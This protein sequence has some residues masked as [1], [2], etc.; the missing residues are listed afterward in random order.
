MEP[1]ADQ[2]DPDAA[3]RR[4]D[5]AEDERDGRSEAE[6]DSDCDCDGESTGKRHGAGARSGADEVSDRSALDRDVAVHYAELRDIAQRAVNWVHAGRP[7]NPTEL[8][9]EGYI[10]LRH[11]DAAL[12]PRPTEFLALAAS[13]LRNC[14]ID[15]VRELRAL[16]RGGD[17][18]R[19]TL[20]GLELGAHREIDLLE[21][22]D[23]LERLAVLDRR[24]AQIVELK[25][26]G[27]LSLAA[28]GEVLGVGERMVKS[29]WTLAT[30]WLHRELRG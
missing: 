30:A 29:E 21:L 16:K 1:P 9:H 24:Q 23:A 3:Q 5:R 27:G 11:R 18:Q 13:V 25:Y 10:R 26:F 19:V 2:P 6:G 7:L 22:D 14:L 4:G 28:I 12:P 17:A 20:T 8:L 15:H